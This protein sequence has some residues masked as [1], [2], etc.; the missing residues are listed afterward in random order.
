M[1]TLS[2]WLFLLLFVPEV[3]AQSASVPMRTVEAVPAEVTLSGAYIVPFASV[4]NVIELAVA[5][6]ADLLAAE[7][8]VTVAERPAWLVV[9]P[10]TVALEDV[11]A[12]GEVLARFTFSVDKSAPVGEIYALHFDI[13]SA[14]TVVG[15]KEIRLQVEA[16]VEIALRGNYPN[17]FNPQTTIT[18]TLTHAAQ[19]D[20][21][22]YDMLGREVVRLV[23]R[24]QAAGYHEATW[25]AGSLASGVYITRL[26]TQD[27]V[28]RRVMR[29][30]TMLLVK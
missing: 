23:R 19:V 3:L 25:Q 27:A 2:F 28:G 5:N 22:V 17:P 24:E 30:K 7:I 15:T 9:E 20:L 14:Q 26:V 11:E 16:P 13:T 1:R 12:G 6:P 29:Q 8:L 4:G 18:Y 10:Q 21:R